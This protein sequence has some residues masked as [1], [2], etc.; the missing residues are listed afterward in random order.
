[1]TSGM[2]ITFRIGQSAGKESKYRFGKVYDSPSTTARI[3]VNNED[4]TNLSLLKIQS[5]PL[6]KLRGISEKLI[7]V[8]PSKVLKPK[9]KIRKAYH[10][11]NNAL[12][13]RAEKRSALA[14]RN[15]L[16]INL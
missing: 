3:S 10:L 9:F 12:T 5:S 14:K 2:V 11:T 15:R 13:N 6:G 8:T 4:L 16:E 1:M 7:L